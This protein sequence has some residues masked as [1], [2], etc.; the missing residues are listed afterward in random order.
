MYQLIKKI[1]RDPEEDTSVRLL[2][3]S[4]NESEIL[5]KN[6]LEALE[7]EYPDRFKVVYT[8][9]KPL[10]SRKWNGEVGFVDSNKIKKYMPSAKDPR[11]LLLVCGPDPYV[12]CFNDSGSNGRMVNM[13]GGPRIADNNQGPLLGTLKQL[14]YSERNV[15]KL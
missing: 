14:G 15:F 10:D 11:T 7:N 1:L 4:R 13:L 5:L 2:Y 6:E 8:V 12:F 3:A 9:D